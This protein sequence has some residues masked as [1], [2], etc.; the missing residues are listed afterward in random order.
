MSE[1]KHYETAPED[2]VPISQKI[3]FGIGMLANNFFT[4]AL[5]VFIVVL[6]EGLGMSPWKAGVLAASPRIWDALTDPIMGYISDNARTK[7]G[8]RKPFIFIGA[9]VTSVAYIIMWQIYP[10]NGESYNF[11]YFLGFSLLFYLGYTIFATPF[12]ALGYEMTP[13]FNERTRIMAI[14]QWFGQ[15][16]WVVVPWFWVIIYDPELYENAVVGCRTLAV[17]VGIACFLFAIVPALFCKERV[18]PERS[19][20]K[21]MSL[22]G[23]G[24]IMKDFFKGI[25]QTFNCK[26]FLLLCLTTFLVFNGFQTVAQYSFYITTSYMFENI[27][28]AGTWPSL[29]GSLTALCTCFF[30]IPIITYLSKKHGKQK[31]FMISTVIAI[32][33]YGLKWWGYTP[34]TP[35]LMVL[36]LPFFS[37]GIGGLFTLMMSMTADV[38]DLDELNTGERREGTFGA[39][40]WWMVKLGQAL[41]LGTSFVVLSLV[42]YVPN[43]GAQSAETIFQLRVAD[44]VIPIVT[45]ILA[46]YLMSKYDITEER[47]HEVRA[48][49]EA[50]RGKVQH[51]G[52]EA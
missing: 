12:V 51:E 29:I 30:A 15:I 41:A 13:D 6:V 35:W 27:G 48:E 50:R 40:Y 39:V 7:W 14:A 44:I 32:I 4:A 47:A 28:V 18:L 22:S 24:D 16:S 2:I 33:G 52:E 25:A 43:A 34:G 31:A 9:I 8:R 37:F 17:W 49:L 38:C 36:P 11:W 42:D 45:S 21:K 20:A 5:S 1:V 46:M 3:A 26:P 23:A 19:D 10:E